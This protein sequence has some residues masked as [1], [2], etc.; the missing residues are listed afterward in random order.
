MRFTQLTGK[1]PHHAKAAR[2]T[3]PNT[4]LHDHR[5]GTRTY[6]LQLTGDIAREIAIEAKAR[7]M[8]SQD[9]IALI[10]TDVVISDTDGVAAG[11]E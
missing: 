5:G 3:L 1:A 2:G 4:S 10:V 6:D 9:L 11:A 7:R 8:S